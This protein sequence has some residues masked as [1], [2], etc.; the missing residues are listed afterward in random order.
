MSDRG[1]KCFGME[2]GEGGG[3]DRQRRD[4][5]IEVGDGIKKCLYQHSYGASP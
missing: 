5:K 3:G 4:F 2:E 1:S